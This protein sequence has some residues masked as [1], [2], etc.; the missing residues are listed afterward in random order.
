[1]ASFTNYA[2][3]QI[4]LMMKDGSGTIPTSYYAAMFKV[5]PALDGTGGT[6]VDPLVNTWYARQLRRMA[7]GCEPKPNESALWSLV[8]GMTENGW[9]TFKTRRLRA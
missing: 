6:E 8:I 4:H 3:Q 9:H 5:T 2:C 7:N 1:M